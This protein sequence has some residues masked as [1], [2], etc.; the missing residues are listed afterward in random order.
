M[1]FETHAHYDDD[2]FDE[3]RD[4][5]LKQLPLNGIGYVVDVG[6]NLESTKKAIKLSEQYDYIYASVGVHP[7]DIEDLNEESYDWLG[8]QMKHK[9]VVAVGEI[10]LDYYWEKE[11]AIRQRQKY[12][13]SRQIELAKKGNLP[14]I[15]HS[16]EAAQDTIAVMKESHAEEVPGIIHCYSYSKEL[17]KIFLDMGYY[18]GIGGVVTFKNARKLVETV[19]E[20][21]MDRLLLETDCPYLAPEPNR[22][23]LNSSLN[24]IYVA[25]KIAEI[26]NLT[27]EEV[28]TITTQN[29][30]KLYRID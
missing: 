9:K 11:D 25:D 17:A 20:T 28:I 19:K 22:G 24:L 15:I 13:F 5:L 27:R 10:G 2:K 4:E 16:R 29:A 14:I 3:N 26:K 12:W 7:S 30:K 18:L 1:I 21:P 8:Q 23:R 6:A